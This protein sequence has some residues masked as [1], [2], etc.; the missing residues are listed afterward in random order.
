VHSST[1]VSI[2]NDQILYASWY[3]P[4]PF[5]VTFNSQGGSSPDPG[6]KIVTYDQAYGAL[7][8]VTRSG[9][10]LEGWW[11]GE[12]GTG[13]QI[14]ATT[15]VSIASEHILYAKWIGSLSIGDIG[16]SGGRVF[17]DKGFCSDGWR[18]LEAA[19]L[20]WYDGNPKDPEKDWQGYNFYTVVEGTG[21]AIGTGASN[22]EKIVAKFSD[23]E[24][25]SNGSDYAAKLC[26]DYRGGGY[27]DWFLPSKDELNQMYQ[28]LKANLYGFY[29][30][31]WSS[32]VYS[33]GSAWGQCFISSNQDFDSG[34]QYILLRDYPFKVRPVRAF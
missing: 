26:A 22:T 14:L 9:Y 28:N 11:T 6:S 5:T 23:A 1:K 24:L 12:N 33:K 32:S 10:L 15:A 30:T 16:P 21:T 7:P 19:R 31:Y 25:Q 20:N 8:V 3:M 27:D 2:T 34:S 4:L 18:Y 13:V 29:G 17:Y